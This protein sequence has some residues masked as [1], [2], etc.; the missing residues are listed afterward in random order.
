MLPLINH[1]GKTK[2]LVESSWFR[3]YFVIPKVINGE[4]GKRVKKTQAAPEF[5]HCVPEV[6]LVIH[7]SSQLYLHPY[8]F[9]GAVFS[10]SLSLRLYLQTHLSPE[11]AR[12]SYF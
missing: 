8:F 3:F 6:V 2:V 10:F 7:F 4:T 1:P 11:A 5:T 9:P 12:T